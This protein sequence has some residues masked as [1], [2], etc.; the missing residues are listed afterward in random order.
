[1]LARASGQLGA[2]DRAALAA[3]GALGAGILFFATRLLEAGLTMK[4][5]HDALLGCTILSAAASFLR[6]WLVTSLRYAAAF[7]GVAASVGLLAEFLGG[8]VPVFGSTYHYHEVLQPMLLGTVPVFV[9]LAWYFLAFQSL[10]VL[11]HWRP[12]FAAAP[13]ARAAAPALLLTGFDVMLDPLATALGLWTW[14]E[15]G[16]FFGVPLLNFAGWFVVGMCIF[17]LAP[18]LEGAEAVARARF[19]LHV[20]RLSAT[21]AGLATALLAAISLRVMASPVLAVGIALVAGP[22]WMAWMR[23]L[24]R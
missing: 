21:V 17:L 15:R 5:T 20:D 14:H 4:E 23:V 22:L 10:L 18:Q 13:L 11:R 3:L 6:A 9:P 7:F 19:H 1:M 2:G 24:L 8:R 16:A 12:A